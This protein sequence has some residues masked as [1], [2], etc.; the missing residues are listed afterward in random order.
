MGGLPPN[1]FPKFR[2]IDSKNFIDIETSIIKEMIEKTIFSAS[3]DNTKYSLASIYLEGEV[4]EDGTQI[5]MVSS[6]GHRLS[7]MEKSVPEKG[8]NFESPIIIPRKGA[9]EIKKLIEGYERLIFGIDDNFCFVICGDD[10]LV[11]RLIDGK[12]PDYHSI[13]PEEKKRYFYF[14]R[15]EVF[16]ALKRISIF[17]SDTTFRGVKVGIEEN[18]MKIESL[19]KEIGEAMEIID[20]DYSGEPFDIAIN[21]KYLMDAL[22]VMDS[23]KVELIINNAKSPCIVT[24]ENDVGFLGAIM[25]MNFI[26]QENN[27]EE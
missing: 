11:I 24:G 2:E 3:F 8:L 23:N 10:H 21:G 20:I 22:S 25:P 17:S 7:L 4:K 18:L 13:I 9:Q 14:D 15:I 1:D 12:F 26:K 16:S 5:R 27:S 6:D 19:Y